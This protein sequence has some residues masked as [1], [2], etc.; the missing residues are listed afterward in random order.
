M[1][2][3]KQLTKPTRW[4]HSLHISIRL[5]IYRLQTFIVWKSRRSNAHAHLAGAQ[6]PP[7]MP[8]SLCF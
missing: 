2:R 1:G 4:R 7:Y 5:N 6:I 3:K 8:E